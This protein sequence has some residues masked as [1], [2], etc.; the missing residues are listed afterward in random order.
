MKTRELAALVDAKRKD[1]PGDTFGFS[2][3]SRRYK[4]LWVSLPKAA[5]VTTALILREL[6]GNPYTGG[7]LWK[8]EGVSTLK[9]F[10]TA[11]I[12]EMLTSQEW[13]RFAFVRNP[14]DRLFS[15][16]KDKIMRSD[17][18]PWYSR[19]RSEIRAAFDYPVR[20]GDRVG[21][22]SFRDFVR[23]IQSGAH[24]CDPHWCVQAKR[25]M[26]DI[27]P[28]DFI[29]R[30]ERFG[31]DFRSVLQRLNASAELLRAELPVCNQT[32]KIPLAA[33]YDRDLAD[34]VYEMNQE[35]F[36]TFGYHRDSWMYQ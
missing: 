8:D 33:A 21:T 2:R 10:T 20:D 12:V 3:V 14:Y 7:D 18:D 29:G 9:D 30:F 26:T 16:Y 1:D 25:L 35:D 13:F 31:D 15:S 23:H 6:D 4:Y 17:G 11:E 27:I 28:Y 19:H 36:E 22:V 32:P 5:S 34:T 24:A